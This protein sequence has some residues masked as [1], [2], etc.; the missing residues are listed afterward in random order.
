MPAARALAPYCRSPSAIVLTELVEALLR[1]NGLG[2]LDRGT[3]RGASLR[4]PVRGGTL[5]MPVRRRP[6]GA[7]AAAGGPLVLEPPGL[8][9]ASPVEALDLLAGDGEWPGLARVRADLADAVEKTAL[10]AEARPAAGPHGLLAW[11]RLASLRD[12]PFLPTAAAKG[13]WDEAAF[14]RY[15]PQ[16][17]ATFPLHWVAVRSDRL[18]VSDAADRAGPAGEVLDAADLA[19]LRAA[20]PAGHVALPV[21]PWQAEHVLPD[22]LEPGIV[23]VD[24]RLG[25]VRAT[26]SVRTVACADRPDVHLKLPLAITSLGAVRTL[27]ARYLRNGERGAR[28]LRELIAAD[29]LL[30]RRL[31]LCDED[32]WWALAGDWFDD[33]VAH[34]GCQLRRY[35]ETGP[36]VP[37]AVAAEALPAERLEEIAERLTEVALA[38]FARGAMPE[39]HGQNV[40]LVLRDGAVER[41]LL[42]DL[43][44]VRV[45]PATNPGYLMKPGRNT[46]VLDT[47][48]ELLAWFQALAIDVGLG[49]A[50]AT[51]GLDEAELWARVRRGVERAAPAS[52]LARELLLERERWPVKHVIAPLL[53]AAEPDTGMP[54]AW[55]SGRNPLLPAAASDPTSGPLPP[56]DAGPLSAAEA[57]R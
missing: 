24:C 36:I 35:P 4:V 37:L 57:R 43:D 5:A 11:E 55:G 2:V 16:L 41:I 13:G 28:L 38:C 33:G 42:R 53:A 49:A 45:L 50:I 47:P 39:L 12:R 20:L 27:P 19:R 30:R 3:L 14:R 31:L 7:L 22:L 54:S 8:E 52:G 44:T 40:L 26:A 17:G 1:E 25:R 23:D 48:E 18:R 34:L 6:S 29:P 56:A 46:L 21:H 51:W 15:G 32:R 10:A 9:V